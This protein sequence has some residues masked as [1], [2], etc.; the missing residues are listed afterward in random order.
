LAPRLVEGVEVPEP[1][2]IARVEILE[3]KVELLEGLPDRVT[4]LEVQIVHLRGELRESVSA[5]RADIRAGDE[6][7]RQEMRVLNAQRRDELRN[8]MTSRLTHLE[9]EL[10]KEIRAGD[11]E[12]RRHMRV[13]HEEVM[14][15]LALIQE[16]R[17]RRK[18]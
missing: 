5:L 15:R 2:L 16:G 12:T 18:K 17:R 8:E 4:A 13:L 6:E 9:R 10:R 14:S 3:Q 11:E 7:T 1:T